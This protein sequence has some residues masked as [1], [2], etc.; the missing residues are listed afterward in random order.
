MT[1][2]ASTGIGG[3]MFCLFY[4]A[5]TK[6]T[7]A[8]NGSGRS[9]S[10]VTLERMRKTLNIP[11]GQDGAI[12]FKSVHSVTIPGCPK[13]WC[14]TVETFG[15]GR[16]SM[17]QIL[18]PAIEL[19]EEGFPVAELSSIL[20]QTSEPDIKRA[21]PNFAE[22]LKPDS[23]APNG[24]RAPE[25][26]EIF[27]NKT[28]AQTFRTLAKEGKKGFYEGRIAEELVKVVQSLG[29][30]LELEDLKK[31]SEEG[32]AEVEP[33]SIK[34]SGQGIGKK[35]HVVMSCDW[36]TLLMCCCSRARRA[37]GA[38]PKWTRFGGT[39]SAGDIAGIGKD[40]QNQDIYP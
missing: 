6:K 20:W 4:D 10:K 34:F 36:A 18:M 26:G 27:H 40:R 14:D 35:T 16:V 11:D 24:C 17:E 1:E 2:P 33:I 23:K 37:V 30:F 13:G 32:D 8:L 9:G 28:L 22:M 19:G 15:S 3:D 25:A 21:S 39:L 31:Y 12:P 5:K 7:R 38:S 29:G